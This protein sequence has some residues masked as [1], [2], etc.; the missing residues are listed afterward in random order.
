MI[1][2]AV[3]LFAALSYALSQQRDGT[4]GLSTE[5][6]RLLASDVIDMGNGLADANARLRLRRIADTAISFENSTVIGYINP[7]CTDD[8][9]KIFAFDGGGRDWENP[10]TERSCMGFYR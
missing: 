8:S 6:V 10:V 2:I 5:K 4:K 1:L 9:C 3:A 7:N